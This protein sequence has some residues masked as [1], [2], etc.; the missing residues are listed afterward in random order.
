MK[1][2]GSDF[3]RAT[4]TAN[5]PQHARLR[6]HGVVCEWAWAKHQYGI[7]VR[8]ESSAIHFESVQV[9]VCIRFICWTKL[10]TGEGSEKSGC[11]GILSTAS[12]TK[13]FI[14]KLETRSPEGPACLLVGC[15]RSQQH[16]SVSQV[17]TCSHSCTCFHTETEVADQTFYLIQSQYID[18]GPAS[19][20]ADPIPPGAWQDCHW[21]ANF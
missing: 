14:L 6:S 17:Q 11:L 12:K 9:V 8:V 19:P 18:T 5:C 1:D 3:L 7:V 21:S 16:A 4:R 2:A 13:C 15:L 20:S 10:L